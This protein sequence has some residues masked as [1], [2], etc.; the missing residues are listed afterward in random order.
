MGHTGPAFLAY[1]NF[2]TFLRWN[3]SLVYATTV[4]YLAARFD[5]APPVARGSAPIPPL[6]RE[7]NIE[8]QKLL[9]ERNYLK[10]EAD[11]KLGRASRAGIKA[12]QLALGLP[13]DSYPT[14]EL[15]ER[16]RPKP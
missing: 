13:A 3:Q 11:G 1:Q 16:L 14:P 9:I 6:Q 5:G 12:A 15:L 10:G 2:R 4:A 8:L 7:Q